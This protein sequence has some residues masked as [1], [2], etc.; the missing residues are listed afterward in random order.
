MNASLLKVN[1]DKTVALV[2][3]SYNNQKKY[4]TMIKISDCDIIL[5]PSA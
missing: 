2:L 3:A 5:C 4:I 1:D